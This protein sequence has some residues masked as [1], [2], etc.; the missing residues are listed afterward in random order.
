VA[1]DARVGPAPQA[2]P[3]GSAPR[4]GFEL[5][6]VVVPLTAILP[7]RTISRQVKASPKYSSVLSSIQEVGVIEPPVVRPLRRDKKGQ[8]YLLLDGHLRVE[9]LRDLGHTEV[10]CLISTDD[11]SYTYNQQINRLVPIQEHYMI[12]RAL[13]RGVSE[14]RIA[15]ALSMDVAAIRERRDLL[16]GISPEA[17][18]LLKATPIARRS[19]LYLREVTPERQVEIAEM[20]NLVNNYTA[21]YCQA[22][23]AATPKDQRV[24]EPKL[25]SKRP[26]IGAADLTRLQREMAALQR[27]LQAAEEDYGRSYLELMGIRGYLK[28]ILANERVLRFLANRHPEILEGFRQIIE[29]TSLEGDAEAL[30]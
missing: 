22:L 24:L 13:A 12:M 26:A 25:T 23:V 21:I 2:S 17:I 7:S 6:G 16:R 4:I 11:E 20:M 29:A 14:E 5:A 19:L 9:A 30:E 27:D 28:R 1:S 3:E 15:R 18:A 10:L 8:Q